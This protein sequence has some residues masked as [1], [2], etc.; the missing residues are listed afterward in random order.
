[1][2]PRAHARR[3]PSAS[4]HGDVRA[5]SRDRSSHWRRHLRSGGARLSVLDR[6][7]QPVRQRRPER[8]RPRAMTVGPIDA[9][10][11][12]LDGVIRH[13]DMTHFD[14]TASALG[15]TSVEFEAIA[16]ARELLDAGMIGSITFEEWADEIG[17]VAAERHGC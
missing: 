5:A 10:I 12:D 15:I 13:W 17:R 1:M 3:R 4:A 7:L 2:D 6:R 8:H 14:A 9:L 11:V 16:F